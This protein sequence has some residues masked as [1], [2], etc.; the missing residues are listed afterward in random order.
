M[1]ILFLWRQ[2]AE[3]RQTQ[4]GQFLAR[5]PTT[6]HSL[7]RRGSLPSEAL[8]PHADCIK[9]QGSPPG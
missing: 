6:P 9:A 1:I 4:V 3:Q 2:Y 5:Y 7:H 8:H